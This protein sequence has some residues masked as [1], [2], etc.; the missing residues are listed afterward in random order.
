MNS[1]TP[2]REAKKTIWNKIP[3]S[4]AIIF[5]LAM[6]TLGCTE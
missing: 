4:K 5:A 3:L 6:N 1:V 2:T